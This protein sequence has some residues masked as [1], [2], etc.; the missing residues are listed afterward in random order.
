MG[1]GVPFIFQIVL[2]LALPLTFAYLISVAGLLL[3]WLR[4]TWKSLTVRPRRSQ[5]GPP[6]IANQASDWDFLPVL[7]GVRP[8]QLEPPCSRFPVLS[9]ARGH[10]ATIGRSPIGPGRQGGNCCRAIK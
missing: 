6:S 7:L 4:V 1:I 9:A 2:M 8:C 3:M 10:V 5:P